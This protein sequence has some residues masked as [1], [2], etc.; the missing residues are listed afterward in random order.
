MFLETEVRRDGIKAL[1]REGDE[2]KKGLS[3]S[4]TFQIEIC[5][6]LRDFNMR[7]SARTKKVVQVR[8]SEKA[9]C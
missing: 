7:E 9:E 6:Y 1:R 8:L 4:V 3:D 5:A 2:G